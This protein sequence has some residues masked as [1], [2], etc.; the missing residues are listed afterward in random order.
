MTA[1]DRLLVTRRFVNPILT[2]CDAGRGRARCR[3]LC[4][5][6]A[7]ATRAEFETDISR[8]TTLRRIPGRCGRLQSP[9]TRKQKIKPAELMNEPWTLRP[10]RHLVRFDCCRGIS[11]MWS[12]ASAGPG[13]YVNDTGSQCAAR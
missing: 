11:G 6:A 4:A 13:Y 10:A 7:L 8:R 5:I 12:R 3:T 9:W 1:N 2:P